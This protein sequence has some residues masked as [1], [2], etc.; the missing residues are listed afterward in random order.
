MNAPI[1]GTAADI[2]KKA[3]IRVHERMMREGLRSRV[4]IQVHDELLVEA[5]LDEEEKVK[6]ILREEMEGASSLKVPLTVEVKSGM[7]WD[8]AK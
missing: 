1:Q 5:F 3:M 8:E 4:L 6:N 2:M 7:N